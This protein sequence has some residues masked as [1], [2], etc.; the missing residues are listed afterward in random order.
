MR[1]LNFEKTK[2]MNEEHSVPSPIAREYS[3]DSGREDKSDNRERR[4]RRKSRGR[5]ARFVFRPP[6]TFNYSQYNGIMQTPIVMPQPTIMVQDTSANIYVPSV[7]QN[8]ISPLK[9]MIPERL[10]G[11]ETIM[12]LHMVPIDLVPRGNLPSLHLHSSDN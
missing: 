2:L 1:C 10:P 9:L 3:D 7:H 8:D 4:K 11:I 12:Q 5:V 6:D